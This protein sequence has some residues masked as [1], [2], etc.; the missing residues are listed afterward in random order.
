[1]TSIITEISEVGVVGNTARVSS[2]TGCTGVGK[3]L[4]T[5]PSHPSSAEPPT[6]KLRHEIMNGN[7]VLSPNDIVIVS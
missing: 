4:H 1:M 2:T 5:L 3:R 7:L 6:W